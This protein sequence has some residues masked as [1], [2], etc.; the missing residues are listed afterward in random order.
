MSASLTA[1]SALYNGNVKSRVE[2][3]STVAIIDA[4]EF[5]TL[6]IVLPVTSPPSMLK[7]VIAGSSVCW[8]T[9]GHLAWIRCLHVGLRVTRSCRV[10]TIVQRFV[11][12]VPVPH[13]P[14]KYRSS[15]GVEW[16]MLQ[17]SVATSC[18]TDQSPSAQDNAVARWAVVDTLVQLFAVL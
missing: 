4:K 1:S 6:A 17:L 16:I 8:R 15:A 14:S 9:R 3:C 7:R 13:V 5:A 18:W 12:R 2:S 11:T 10:A